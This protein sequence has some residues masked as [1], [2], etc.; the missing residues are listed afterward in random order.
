MLFFDKTK[1]C[2]IRDISL[3]PG[4]RSDFLRIQPKKCYGI[5]T[6]G[7]RNIP[8]SLRIRIFENPLTK[9]IFVSIWK[10]FLKNFRK[11]WKIPKKL[12]NRKIEK[13]G[14]QLKFSSIFRDFSRFSTFSKSKIFD[15][16]I[17]QKY[18]SN[19]RKNIFCQRIFKN[20]DA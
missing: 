14:F 4:F 8:A 2:R 1:R 7:R 5:G 18:F 9:N 20:P 3:Y 13:V 6:Y 16:K 19:R 17:F 15:V 10:I 11:F 12:E